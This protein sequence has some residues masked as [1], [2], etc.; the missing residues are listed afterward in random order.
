MPFG[1][2]RRPNPAHSASTSAVT[3]SN[4]AVPRIARQVNIDAGLDSYF[5][6]DPFDLPR[7]GE[8]IEMIYRTWKEVAVDA[9]EE[10]DSEDDDDEEESA[11]DS[12]SEEEEDLGD[13]PLSD[14]LS[15]KTTL[16][17]TPSAK[18]HKGKNQLATSADRRRAVKDGG[19]SSSFDG[20]SIS[21]RFGN[22][23]GNKSAK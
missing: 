2:F 6:F 21:P 20:M 15:P 1:N 22:L 14:H 3:P 18:I 13:S 7:S 19:L 8:R 11:A 16:R 17:Q 10:S 23:A 9:G 5:P 12:D 4:L